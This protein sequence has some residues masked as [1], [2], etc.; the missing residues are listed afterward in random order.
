M[1]NAKKP[2]AQKTSSHPPY[3]QMIKEALTALDE[4]GGSSPYAIAKYMEEKHKSVLPENFRKTL[5]Q[6]LKN[7]EAKGKL[8]KVKASY[9]L[10]SKD[11]GKKG[12]DKKETSTKSARA[13]A[14]KKPGQVGGDRKVKEKKRKE[15]TEKKT[16]G[17]AGSGRKTVKAKKSAAGV[18]AKQPKSIKSQPVG[19]KKR[20]KMV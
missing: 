19:D 9:K 20:G 16:K 8:M 5:G 6:Q 17:S 3:F 4:K 10:S 2:S 7:N 15:E 14:E 13:N 1:E 12:K 18:K 11:V